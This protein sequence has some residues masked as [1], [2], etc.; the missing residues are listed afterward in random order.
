MATTCPHCG[1]E[2]T[3]RGGNTIWIVSVVLIAIAIPAVL[4]LHL[5]AAI[6]GGVII[7]VLVLAHLLLGERVCVDCGHQWRRPKG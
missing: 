2:K 4:V 3:R 5:N 1:S 6:I 7:A